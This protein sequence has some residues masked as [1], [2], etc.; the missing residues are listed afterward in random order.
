MTFCSLQSK[1]YL[2]E[3][4]PELSTFREGWI[5][6]YF[7]IYTTR[8]DLEKIMS[9]RSKTFWQQYLEV[10]SGQSTQFS[11]WYLGLKSWTAAE[12]YFLW[13]SPSFLDH[14]LDS[15]RPEISIIFRISIKCIRDAVCCGWF[16]KFF[17]FLRR[18]KTVLFN[19][20]SL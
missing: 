20:I 8:R 2:L 6:L 3:L 13:V 1:S 17:S 11:S 7:Q 9:V 4:H 16:L 10:D 14:L 5:G 19:E 15:N 12:H 18:L